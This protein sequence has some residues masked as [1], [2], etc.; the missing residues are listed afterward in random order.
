MHNLKVKKNNNKKQGVNGTYQ[1]C[2]R[3]KLIAFFVF[4][5]NYFKMASHNAKEVR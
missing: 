3:N 1:E 2:S 4:I 5:F